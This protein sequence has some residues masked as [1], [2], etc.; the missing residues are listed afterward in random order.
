MKWKLYA[1]EAAKLDAQLSYI[2]GGSSWKADSV[3]PEQGDDLVLTGWVSIQNKTGKVF[4]NAKIK[5]V[6]GD[7]HKEAPD[8]RGML[9]EAFAMSARQSAP[10]VESEKFDEF[11]VYRLPLPAT[12]YDGET[13]QVEFIRS[14]KVATKRFYVYDGAS[15]P[16][17][18]RSWQ[19]DGEPKLRREQ[20]WG[21][22]D[23]PGV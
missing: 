12:L 22:G 20:S 1:E 5:L 14:E 19:D 15:L 18:A 4:E 6:A 9:T 3:L 16:W 13:K 11:H 8:Q 7:V 21:C 17:L 10:K 23:L 2:T